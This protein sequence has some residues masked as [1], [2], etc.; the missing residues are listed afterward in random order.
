MRTDPFSDSVRFLVAG[1]PAQLAL[2]QLRIPLAA[3]LAVLLFASALVAVRAWQRD[4]AQRSVTHGWTAFCR[5][6]MGLMWFQGALWKLP[7]PR[8]DG[9]AYWTGQ[10][11]EHAAFDVHRRLV[12]DVLLPNLGILQTATFAAEMGMAISLILGLWVRPFSLLGIAF[13]LQLWLG[14]Y[15]HPGEWPWLFW[16]MVFTLGLFAVHQ[17]GRS[18][19]VDALRRPPG[20]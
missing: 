14:L 7:L 18:L 19:G 20:G 15:H 11:V 5:V 9:F 8:S 12:R 2:G 1:D 13:A 16:F 6:M 4:P 17:A 10:L 3:L